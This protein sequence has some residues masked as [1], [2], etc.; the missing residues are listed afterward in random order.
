MYTYSSCSS[1]AKLSNCICALLFLRYFYDDDDDDDGL[2][3][4]ESLR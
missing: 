2:H 4:V 3:R 1:I